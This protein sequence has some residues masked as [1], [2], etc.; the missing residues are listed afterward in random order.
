MGSDAGQVTV[1]IP[2]RGGSKTL[3]LKNI[4]VMAGRPLIYWTAKACSDS[5][6][7]Q[8]TFVATD[9][10]D[11][12]RCVEGLG[13]PRVR[14]IDR[15][16][17]SATDAAS[18]ESALLEFA[19]R[20]PA[21]HLALVQATSP[22]L[23]A[24]DVTGAVEKYF[25]CGADSLLTVVRTKRFLWAQRDGRVEPVNYD[26]ARRPRR[27]D[28]EGQLVENGAMYVTSRERLLASGCRVS[29]CIAAY[30]MPEASYYEIDERSDWTI[31]ENLLLAGRGSG[32][33]LTRTARRLRLLCVDVDGTL[34]DAGMY[35]TEAG[36]AMKRF[37]TRDA[38]GMGRLRRRGIE[39]AIMTAEDSPIVLARARKLKI[40]HVYVG[41]A[42]KEAAMEALL[43]RLG[44]RWEQLAYVGDDL[45]DLAVMRRAGFS[46][47]P[48]DAAGE[49]IRHA[50]YVCRREGGRG[51]VR[52]VC[53][54]IEAA[55]DAAPDGNSGVGIE[56]G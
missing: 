44:L 22:L 37:N 51:A 12:R 26:P 21:D 38:L 42:N 50:G 18:S 13:L 52:E 7:V 25:S 56:G 43:A 55:L 34:T 28:W 9:S 30:E 53:D 35:Y 23:T 17:A 19:E 47:C 16:T 41:V 10:V 2:A 36:E 46:A 31:V 40:E 54:L 29:G 15:S 14:V 45:N 5:P 32:A 3:P 11:I 27:Q 49:I 48:A 20:H 1:F 33:D 6:R 39:S 8:Q 24:D 4:A